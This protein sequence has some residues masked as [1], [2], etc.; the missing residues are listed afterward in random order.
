MWIKATLSNIIKETDLTWKFVIKPESKF[1]FKPGQF[2][3]IKINAE[4]WA[5]GGTGRRVGLKIQ[6]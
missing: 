3:Q 1:A 4:I 5:N 2:V 6:W